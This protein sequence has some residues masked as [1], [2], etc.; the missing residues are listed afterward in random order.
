MNRN[1]ISTRYLTGWHV[2][3]LADGQR[4]GEYIVRTCSEVESLTAWWL[5]GG[6]L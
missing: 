3:L 2:E 1:A 6:A 4:V 5:N